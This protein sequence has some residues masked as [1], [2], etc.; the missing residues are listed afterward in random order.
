MPTVLAWLWGNLKSLVIG[1]AI[2]ALLLWLWP[3]STFLQWLAGIIAGLTVLGAAFSLV[4][5]VP[6]SPHPGTAAKVQRDG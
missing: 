5:P 2:A 3:D 4:I 6:V 1:L